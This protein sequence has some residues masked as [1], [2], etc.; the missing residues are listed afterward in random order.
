MADSPLAAMVAAQNNIA[1]VVPPRRGGTTVRVLQDARYNGPD[2]KAKHAK[3][4]DII[5]VAGGQ[6][7]SDLIASGMVERYDEP[8]DDAQVDEE[9]DGDAQVDDEKSG[10][11]YLDKLKVAELR[12]MAEAFGIDH[13]GMKKAELIAAMQA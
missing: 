9:P 6:Y 12:E 4:N 1:Q 3:A 5:E 11:D 8:D 2:H 7:A 10:N 13:T